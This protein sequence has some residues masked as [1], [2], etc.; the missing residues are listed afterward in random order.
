MRVDRPRNGGVLAATLVMA[1]A[2]APLGAQEAG[3]Q[4]FLVLS[5]ERLLTGSEAGRALLDE[6]ARARDALRA[7]AR[8]I[9]AAFEAEERA[10]TASR[11]DLTPEDFRARADDFDARVVVARRE[12]NERSDALAQEF[13]QKRREFYAAVAPLLVAIMERR[14]AEV[15]LDEN[16]VL[17]A[18][19]AI[20]ITDA[21]IAE[22]DAAGR[23]ESQGPS[24]KEEP[25]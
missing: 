18:D 11:S 14:R 10:L 13:D 3:P 20:N 12:Q 16:T 8:A 25:R 23:P 21:V 24:E 1:F 9:D 7:E 22:I 19:Q 4:P 2:I 17:L 6:E 15:I 5:Q